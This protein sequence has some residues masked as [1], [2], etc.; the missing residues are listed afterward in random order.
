MRY[1]G[2]KYAFLLEMYVG[3]VPLYVVIQKFL[4]IYFQESKQF[5]S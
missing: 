4:T 2:Y 5:M 3:S 1:N